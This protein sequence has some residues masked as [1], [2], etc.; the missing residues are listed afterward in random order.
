[1]T[2]KKSKNIFAICEY[3]KSVFELIDLHMGLSHLAQ[4]K[5]QNKK[6]KTIFHEAYQNQSFI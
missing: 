2:D 5:E 3:H 1:M 4:T 6:K